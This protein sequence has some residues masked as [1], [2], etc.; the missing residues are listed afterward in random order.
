[1]PTSQYNWTEWHQETGLGFEGSLL[2]DAFVSVSA[3]DWGG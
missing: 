3:R 1:M 2:S